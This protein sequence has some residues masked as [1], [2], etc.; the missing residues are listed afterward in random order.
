MTLVAPVISSE[1][2]IVTF[3]ASSTHSSA[4]WI[5]LFDATT[6]ESD[7]ASVLAW[8]YVPARLTS[9]NVILEATD[10]IGGKSVVARYVH[11]YANTAVATSAPLLAQGN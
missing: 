7:T 5:G 8:T 6:P 3:T 10:N 2:V 9:G 11:W 1:R 4:D